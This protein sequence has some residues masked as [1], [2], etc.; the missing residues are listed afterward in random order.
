MLKFGKATNTHLKIRHDRRWCVDHNWLP[1]NRA[2]QARVGSIYLRLAW[3]NTNNEDSRICPIYARW[4]RTRLWACN[5]GNKGV[6]C[7]SW[8]D[9]KLWCSAKRQS[10]YDKIAAWKETSTNKTNKLHVL[11]H[12][13]WLCY[14]I[15]GFA[16]NPH[17]DA[18]FLRYQKLASNVEQ[19]G[20]W[21]EFILWKYLFVVPCKAN[22]NCMCIEFGS[23]SFQFYLFSKSIVYGDGV[24][25]RNLILSCE[26]P[27][28]AKYSYE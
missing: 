8:R 13:L 7:L 4:C 1:R 18:L 14:T 10:H 22:C 17:E 21:H 27:Q 11:M 26:K 5:Q 16:A 20:F 24:L 3:R 23:Q 9:C 12:S 15:R 2:S 25:V 28:H 19:T 6:F